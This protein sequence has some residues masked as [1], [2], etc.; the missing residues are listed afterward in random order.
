MPGAPDACGGRAS[1]TR[2]IATPDTPPMM[3]FFKEDLLSRGDEDRAKNIA[4]MSNFEPFRST[5]FGGRELASS[6][7]VRRR[8][9]DAAHRSTPRSPAPSDPPRQGSY[10]CRDLLVRELSEI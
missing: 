7:T 2:A 8:T 3:R 10:G 1:A 9:P 6:G 5:R 4:Y